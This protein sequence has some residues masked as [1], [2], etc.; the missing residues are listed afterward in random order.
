MAN[1]EVIFDEPWQGRMF[2][3]ARAMAEAGLFTWDEFRGHLIDAVARWE[4]ANAADPAAVYQYYTQFQLALEELLARKGLI[5]SAALQDR[6]ETFLARPP[7]H[8]H[9]H[10]HEH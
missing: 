3:M 10:D 9:T 7:G 8:D 5:G 1:G 6:T 2:G 4:N